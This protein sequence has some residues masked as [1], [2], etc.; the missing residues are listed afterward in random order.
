MA[1]DVTGAYITDISVSYNYGCDLSRRFLWGDNS[2][3]IKC[4]GENKNLMFVGEAREFTLKDQDGETIDLNKLNV[5]YDSTMFKVE[6]STNGAMVTALQPFTSGTITFGNKNSSQSYTCEAVNIKFTQAD[7]DGWKYSYTGNI[8]YINSGISSPQDNPHNGS[9]FYSSEPQY[10][11]DTV[12][13]AF[14]QINDVYPIW[15]EQGGLTDSTLERMRYAFEVCHSNQYWSN[16]Y[17]K[18]DIYSYLTEH[19]GVCDTYTTMVYNIGRMLG[20]SREDVI[21]LYGNGTYHTWNGIKLDG[22]YYSIDVGGGVFVENYYGYACDTKEE[23]NAE[24]EKIKGQFETALKTFSD[25]NGY[26]LKYSSEE[27]EGGDRQG[28]FSI[29]VS[30]D[31]NGIQ[32][33]ILSNLK[34]R[35]NF[36]FTDLNPNR[37]YKNA[38]YYV[39]FETFFYNKGYID[40]VCYTVNP[41][42]DLKTDNKIS[43]AN[44]EPEVSAESTATPTPSET[45][46]VTPSVTA[47]PTETAEPEVTAEPAE[48]TGETETDST[49]TED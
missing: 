34:E 14:N 7:F 5:E 26:Q 11:I 46:S 25:E 1:V 2:V 17:G 29:D 16:R 31:D 20:V 40:V 15:L 43:T 33:E 13:Y 12:L 19:Y 44:L 49:I 45:P 28:T 4:S 8:N 21:G 6:K 23:Y 36:D 38:T 35:K 24:I 48:E 39:K 37:I 27:L 9:P 3:S 32:S 18:G 47:E 10:Q 41:T 42:E 22:Q 30:L